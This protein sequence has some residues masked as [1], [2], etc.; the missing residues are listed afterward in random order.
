MPTQRQGGVG[1]VLCSFCP[2]VVVGV[3]GGGDFVCVCVSVCVCVCMCVCMC[4]CECVSVY[5]SLCCAVVGVV[6]LP[7]HMGSHTPSSEE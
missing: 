3:V 5:V 7:R 6:L 2:V 1:C 4:V